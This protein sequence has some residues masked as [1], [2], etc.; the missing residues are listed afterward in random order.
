MNEKKKKRLLQ[1]YEKAEH[2][3]LTAKRLIDIDPVILDNACFHCQQ[4]VEKYLKAYLHYQG[5]PIRKTHSLD[6]LAKQCMQFD[7]DFEDL[8]FKNLEDYAA[9]IRYPDD[10]LVPTIDETK[11]YLQMAED[12]KKLVLVKVQLD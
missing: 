12:I 9:D 8:N 6:F 7:Y 11:E 3:I 1:W 10:S 4:A 5:Q 2:D